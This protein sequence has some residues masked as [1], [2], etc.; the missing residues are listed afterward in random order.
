MLLLDPQLHD[1]TRLCRS[2]P[3]QLVSVILYLGL[4]LLV[5][6]TAIALDHRFPDLF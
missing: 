3:S 6:G 1:R 5:S 2:G 4:L